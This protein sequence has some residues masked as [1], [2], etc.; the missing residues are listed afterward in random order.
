MIKKQYE[1][2]PGPRERCYFNRFLDTTKSDAEAAI[3]L[4]KYGA[5]FGKSKRRTL[6]NVKWYD[7]KKYT[8]FV[9]RWS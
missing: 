9:L 7:P 8:L 2:W 1:E 5:K 6:L 3:E 4:S